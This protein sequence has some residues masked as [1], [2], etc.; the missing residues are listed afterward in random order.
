MSRLPVHGELC[1]CQGGLG[2]R[3]EGE[4]KY[5]I[6]VFIQFSFSLGKTANS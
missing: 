3:S 1:K 6:A 4:P 5:V 2:G